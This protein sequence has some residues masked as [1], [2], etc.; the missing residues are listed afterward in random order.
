VTRPGVD[1]RVTHGRVTSEGEPAL[2]GRRR[3]VA[4]GGPAPWLRKLSRLLV[5]PAILGT[6]AVAGCGAGHTSL[7]VGLAVVGATS[8]SAANPIAA[9]QTIEFVI[10]V[11]DAGTAGTAG[12]TVTANLPADFRYTDTEAL[13]GSAM[14]TSPLDP[15]G[16]SQQ[17]TW[18]VWELSGHATNVSIN[19]YAL[20]QGN[21]GTYTMT[22]S[23]SA[24]TASTTQS[25]GVLLKLTP[26]PLLSGLVTVSPNV[27][28][29]GEDVTYKVTVINSG[30]GQASDVSV[31]VTLPP[32]FIYDGSVA[33]TGNSGRIGGNDAVEGSAI[34]YF[35]GFVVPA[36]GPSGPGKLTISFDAQVLSSAGAEGAYPVGVQVLG[37]SGLE[38]VDIPDSAPVQVT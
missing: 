32:V 11:T 9:N 33:I 35:D 8:A 27:A 30:T 26:A 28:A 2:A 5:L 7:S 19:F 24:S 14:R 36:Q 34:P 16:K 20:A 37:D 12:L 10:T 6:V 25:N 3:D 29:P 38:R 31:L 1:P 13:T 18:G 21:P 15:Q 4:G 23:A 17:P 22:A